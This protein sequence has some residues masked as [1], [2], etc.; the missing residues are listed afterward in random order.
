MKPTTTGTSTT[1]STS[2]LDETPWN[3]N[4][5]ALLTLAI[6]VVALTYS[7][8]AIFFA[9][10]K[11]PFPPL[12][13]EGLPFTEWLHAVC[14][15]GAHQQ[16]QWIEAY[17]PVFLIKS[18]LA[19]LIPNN[20][21]IANPALVKELCTK[22][23]NMYRPPSK[24]SS[25]APAFA[26]ATRNT[27]GVG[28]TG[29]LGEEWRWRK[30]AIIKE[31][32]KN[33]MLLD[34]RGLVEKLV[35]EGQKMCRALDKAA[36]NGTPVLVDT[37]TTGAA[38]GVILFFLF[39]RDLEFDSEELRGSATDLMECLMY[40]ILNPGYS[41]YKHCPG[42]KSHAMERLKLQ[43]W[44]VVDD[45]CAPEITMLLQEQAGTRAVHPDRKPGSVIASLIATEPRFRQGGVDGM[46]AEARV[47]VQAGFET[48]AH[49]LAFSLGM[50]AERPDLAAKMAAQGKKVLG[51]SN[52]IG[53]DV[54]NVDAVREA[55]EG[56]DL[57]LVKN[58]FMESVRLY[59][60]APA[61]GG[62][63]TDDI[64]IET[65]N[66]TLYGLAKGTN[67]YFPNMALQRH[68]L[69]S[70]GIDPHAIEPDRW[71]AK[72]SDQPFLHTFNNGPHA[73]PGK[74]LS[75]LEG[76]VFLL[77]AA[78]QFEFSFPE[79]G[80]TKVEFKENLLLRPK[81]G[82]PLIVKRRS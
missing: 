80:A 13:P 63:C 5:H 45:I 71:N 56:T 9:K 19:L 67:V 42:T 10:K 73:C 59:P 82:M 57:D 41:F 3:L 48:T 66:G 40:T 7:T 2:F 74:P 72:P 35:E 20:V 18:P 64:V 52:G 30:D 24:F 23:A 81:D 22:Q 4:S 26:A 36:V 21:C 55:L 68:P 53:N 31:F 27:V 38:V 69:Y 76:Q 65:A 28:V 77:L 58:F 1:S 50:M 37:L 25:R 60:L 61:L 78:M 47:F 15:G 54:Y 8:Y 32:H 79:G 17:G 70:K 46:I 51:S 6:A 43:A 14:A 29:L 33:R 12:P 34:Q 49:S 39:G 44:N 11:K 16:L 75:M 62:V